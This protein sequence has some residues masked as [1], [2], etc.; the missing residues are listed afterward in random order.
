METQGPWRESGNISDTVSMTAEGNWSNCSEN[1]RARD[2]RDSVKGREKRL[3][4]ERRKKR[5]EKKRK[6]Q[7]KTEKRSAGCPQN[8][9]VVMAG[10]N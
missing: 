5:K 3:E 7:L 10:S 4:E 9:G 2:S 6:M 8:G 1:L